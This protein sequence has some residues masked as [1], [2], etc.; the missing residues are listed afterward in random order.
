MIIR[1]NKT[2]TRQNTSANNKWLKPHDKI[3]WNYKRSKEIAPRK[4]LF[5]ILQEGLNTA[6]R[7]WCPQTIRPTLKK[8]WRICYPLLRNHLPKGNS[9]NWNNNSLQVSSLG[10]IILLCKWAWLPKINF[11]HSQIPR[12]SLLRTSNYL[13][14]STNLNKWNKC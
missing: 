14:S 6:D 4:N 9:N 11:L 8:T 7:D 13:M 10:H 1:S 12:V 5:S 2:L 3:T